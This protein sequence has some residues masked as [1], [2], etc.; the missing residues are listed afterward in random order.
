MRVVLVGL[1]DER[2]QMRAHL[3]STAAVVAEFATVAA[4][5]ASAQAHDALLIA[6]QAGDVDATTV[7]VEPLTPREMEVVALLADGLS[8]K[9]IGLRLGISDQTVKFHVAAI[10][11]RLGAINRTDA[12]RRA[13]RRGL[14]AA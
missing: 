12:V 6:E 8:N 11:A 13:L 1:P 14:V 5:R 3:A 2:R 7:R 10:C 4:A 9:A